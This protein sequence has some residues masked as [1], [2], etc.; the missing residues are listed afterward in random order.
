MRWSHANVKDW[1]RPNR[2]HSSPLAAT[3]DRQ[4]LPNRESHSAAFNP[5][6]CFVSNWMVL[7]GADRNGI[8]DLALINS[9]SQNAT[10]IPGTVSLKFNLPMPII[11]EN[12]AVS[13]RSDHVRVRY[14]EQQFIQLP[15]SERSKPNAAVAAGIP[16]TGQGP[17]YRK[18]YRGANRLR[19][20]AADGS[21]EQFRDPPEH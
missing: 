8:H 4:F 1:S 17:H 21:A 19:D 3:A 6:T 16:A 9:G 18:P 10:T 14:F 7:T 12:D 2:L 15:T 5:R 11:P 20:L 13:Q